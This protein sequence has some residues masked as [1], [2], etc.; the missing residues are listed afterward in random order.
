MAN[1][2]YG[3]RVAKATYDFD[4]HGGAT[5]D[6]QSLGVIVP[7]GAIIMRCTGNVQTTLASD[8]SATVAINVGSTELNAATA[9][10]DAT[11]VA[12]DVHYDT[13]ASG[14]TPVVLTSDSEV[15]I[16]IAGAAL[17]AGKYDIYVEYLY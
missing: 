1:E 14:D 8:G 3:V 16:D 11:Y 10:D 12:A 4:V 6:G 15:N 2:F 7:E 5:G 17:T 13:A 9:F